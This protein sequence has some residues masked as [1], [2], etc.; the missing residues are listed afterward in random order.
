MF[1]CNRK[2]KRR[3]VLAYGGRCVIFISKHRQTEQELG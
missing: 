2:N 3:D 1:E